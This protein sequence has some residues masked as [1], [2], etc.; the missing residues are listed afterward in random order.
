MF[1]TFLL[2]FENL[3]RQTETK[4]IL[5]L[6]K[7][8]IVKYAVVVKMYTTLIIVHKRPVYEILKM[9]TLVGLKI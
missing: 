8:F 6:I 9:S 2:T 5:F 7:I 1:Y 4:N 3:G